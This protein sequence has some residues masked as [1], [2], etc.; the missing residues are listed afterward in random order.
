MMMRCWTKVSG[1]W[2]PKECEPRSWSGDERRT[3]RTMRQTALMVIRVV[4]N[5]DPVLG[6]R[7]GFHRIAAED[8]F[9]IEGESAGSRTSRGL[10][11]ILWSHV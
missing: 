9:Q 10:L 5:D 11:P 8:G 2:T 7:Y 1:G 6:T 4:V 3:L